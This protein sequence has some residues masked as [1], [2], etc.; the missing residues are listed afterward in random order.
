M[1]FRFFKE[2]PHP[3]ENQRSELGREL[4]LETKQIKFWFQNKRTQMKTLTERMDN[5]VLRAENERMQCEN[6]AIKEALKTVNCPQCGGP[7]ALVGTD[8]RELTIQ[9]LLQENAHLRQEAS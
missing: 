4:G 5:N 2:C 7:A 1:N 8:E 6:L 3:D 9:K